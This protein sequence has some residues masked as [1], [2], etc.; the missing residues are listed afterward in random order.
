MKTIKPPH[1][2]S[3]N[4]RRTKLVFLAGSIEMGKAEDWQS[5]VEKHF[6]AL[7]D[8]TV[9]NPRR[10]DCDS[11]WKQEFENPNFYQQVNWEL[12]GLEKADTIIL[13]LAPETKAPISL[14]E[15]G[16]FAD[17]GKILVCCPNGYWRKGNVEVVCERYNIPIYDTLEELLTSNFKIAFQ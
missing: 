8:Y 3:K 5:K 17:S 9:L 2:I 10:D 12:N 16:L 4:H 1:S 15:L 14:L 6:E 7:D 11:S 13:Y